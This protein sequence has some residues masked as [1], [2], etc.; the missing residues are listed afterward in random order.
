MKRLLLGLCIAAICALAA[1]VAQAQT[2]CPIIDAGTGS[3]VAQITSPLPGS[4]LP[5]GAVTFTWCNVSADYFLTIESPAGAANIYNA[6]VVGQESVTLGP[7]CNTPSATDPTIQCIPS[8][9]ET[10]YVTLWTNVAQSGRKNFVAAPTMTYTAPGTAASAPRAAVGVYRFADAAFYLDANRSGTWDGCGAD[11]CINWGGDPADKAVVGDW[12]NDGR[13][14]IGIYRDGTW[15]LDKNGN[16]SFD[17]CPAECVTWGGLPTD[18]PMVGDW[19]N[20]GSTKVGIYRDGTWYLDKNG[21]G[22]FD[23]CPAECNSWGG[24]PTDKPM[25]GDWNGNGTAKVGIYRDGTWYLDTNGNGSFD[26]CGTDN[27]IPMGQNGDIP[28]VGKW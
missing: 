8:R 18:R 17:G 15:Y 19:N 21:N 27:C 28:L 5:A 10:I 9:G 16:G 3:R 12:N 6:F 24:L 11:K 14:K 13:T 7:S 1:T 4:T 25:V 22:S 2:A 20:T 23:G 26:G